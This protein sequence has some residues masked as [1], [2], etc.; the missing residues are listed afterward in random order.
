MSRIKTNKMK[1]RL[2]FEDEVLG[3]LPNNKDVYV[4]FIGSKAPDA[5]T[6]EEEV[7][8]IGVDKYAEKTIT[9]F[10]RKPGDKTLA[11]YNY[12]I[13]GFFKN[14]CSALRSVP[15]TESSK[16]K[17]YKKKIDNQVFVGP[18]F[19]QILDPEGNPITE[20]S[21][22]CQRPLRAQTAQ[23]ERVSL[24]MSET[25]PAGS[26]IEFTIESLIE[27]DLELIREWLDYGRFNGLGQ[28]HNGGKGIFTWE[29][30]E[31][32]TVESENGEEDTAPKKR[33]RKP[34]ATATE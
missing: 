2:T 3:T 27:S 7:E 23:G 22:T 26:Y 29:E 10:A 31:T 28:W 1:V 15:K 4:E 6:M 17:A 5:A 8:A 16:I 18:R 19:I 9:V 20:P 11:F 33:G 34:K 21:E 14:A 24:A 32:S 12:L 25:I 13:K 30:L